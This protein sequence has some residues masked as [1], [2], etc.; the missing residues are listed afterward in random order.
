[1]L[2]RFQHHHFTASEAI[3]WVRIV[4]PGSVIGQ[5]QHYLE[6]V[7][8]RL[9]ADGKNGLFAES[10][11]TSNLNVGYLNGL[12]PELNVDGVNGPGES[13][14]VTSMSSSTE[15][16][17]AS[18]VTTVH[19]D[20]VVE[21]KIITVAPKMQLQ[22]HPSEVLLTED[23][24]QTTQGDDLNARKA[25]RDKARQNRCHTRSMN[26]SVAAES[27]SSS[28]NLQRRVSGKKAKGKKAK[29][30]KIK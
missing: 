15:Y 14:E 21:K 6:S 19:E 5:Q 22:A 3:A 7:K 17:D 11:K 9:W 13:V 23:E 26:R 2:L 8:D 24:G 27:S 29:K 25:M 18:G 10:L 20:V 1:M 12:P 30:L 16:T 28:P 4:R